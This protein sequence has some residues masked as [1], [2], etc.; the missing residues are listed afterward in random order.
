M[1]AEYLTRTVYDDHT[2]SEQREGFTPPGIGAPVSVDGQVNPMGSCGCSYLRSTFS[3]NTMKH[4]A[5]SRC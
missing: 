1:D 3:Q 5:H 4:A 2:A